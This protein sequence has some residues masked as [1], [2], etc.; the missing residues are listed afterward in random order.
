MHLRRTIVL[1]ALA[2][3]TAAPSALAM[4]PPVDAGDPGTHILTHESGI[5][6]KN[7]PQAKLC[8]RGPYGQTPCLAFG[9]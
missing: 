4:R 8:V 6:R 7:A 9:F 1:V 2:A 5:H 3:A